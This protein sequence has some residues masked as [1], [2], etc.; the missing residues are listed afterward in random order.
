VCLSPEAS[1]LAAGALAPVG[2]ATLRAAR[3]RNE[4]IVASLPLLF[5]L[6]QLTE[7][8]VWL[9][10]QGEISAA[11]EQAA[12]RVY[13]LFAQVALPLLV[14][15][16]M[17]LLEPD[18]M[19]RRWMLALLGVGAVVSLRLL[20]VVTAHPVGAD[21]LD[22]AIAYDTDVLFG[23][24]VGAGYVAA[25]CGPVLLSTRRHLRW[26]GVAN[27]V[28]LGLASAIRYSAVTSVWCAYAALVSVL[29][30]LHFRRPAAAHGELRPERAGRRA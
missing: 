30:L 14:P 20:W 15:L 16:G 21:D 4:L 24:W 23:A 3:A 13:L 9:G 11:A 18:R 10:V 19:R 5:A 12:T 22:R 28:G 27:L 17:L 25:T 2:V 1:F 29:I 26:F 8:F 6:H 7:G